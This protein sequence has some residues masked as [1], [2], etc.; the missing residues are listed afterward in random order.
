MDPIVAR[1]VFPFL[2]NGVSTWSIQQIPKQLTEN[3]RKDNSFF[4]A[5]AGD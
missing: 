4:L 1:L 5:L 2:G 3:K